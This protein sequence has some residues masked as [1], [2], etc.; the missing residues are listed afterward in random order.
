MSGALGRKREEILHDVEEIEERARNMVEG[1]FPG[2]DDYGTEPPVVFLSVATVRAKVED[3]AK[4]DELHP[5]KVEDEIHPCL[6]CLRCR[7]PCSRSSHWAI[8]AR[9]RGQVSRFRVCANDSSYVPRILTRSR[10]ASDGDRVYAGGVV[11]WSL[12]RWRW[13]AIVDSVEAPITR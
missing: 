10:R 8:R 13:L 11:E 5:S 7:F 3:R 4:H 9:I 12:I 1:Q 6:G 2:V